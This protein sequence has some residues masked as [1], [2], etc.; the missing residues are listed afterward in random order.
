M[1]E[2]IKTRLEKSWSFCYFNPGSD[3]SF[4]QAIEW[5]KDYSSRYSE[6]KNPPI[7]SDFDE[8]YN[9]FSNRIE[10]PIKELGSGIINPEKIPLI[11]NYFDI[12]LLLRGE[13]IVGDV[14]KNIKNATIINKSLVNNSFNRVEKEYDQDVAKALKQVAEFIE[15]SGNISAGILFD[16]FNEEL[17]KPKPEKSTLSKIWDGIV[18]TLPSI[19]TISEVIV[20]LAPLFQ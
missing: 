16:K 10:F 8:Y 2:G 15:K 6:M 14:I 3:E 1:N 4:I 5:L 9:H 7:L 18:K 13:I 17:N 20:K 19:A 11:L 12:N